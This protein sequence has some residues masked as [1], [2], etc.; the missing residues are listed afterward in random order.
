MMYARYRADRRGQRHDQH[1]DASSVHMKRFEQ[2]RVT[3]NQPDAAA[4]AKVGILDKRKVNTEVRS[5]DRYNEHGGGDDKPNDIN[6][7]RSD[8]SYRP[9]K[10]H[11]TDR[12]NTS[13]H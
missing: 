9:R 2:E 13:R 4:D 6:L 12:P 8:S 3:K 5:E 1:A 10:H 11:G 7:N